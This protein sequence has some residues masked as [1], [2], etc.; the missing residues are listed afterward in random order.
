MVNA[1]LMV[2]R[3]TSMREACAGCITT[4]GV[5]AAWVRVRSV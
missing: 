4:G 1:A 5:V 3:V 2:V